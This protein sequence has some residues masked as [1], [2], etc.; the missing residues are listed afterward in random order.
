MRLPSAFLFLLACTGAPATAQMVTQVDTTGQAG[1]P[2]DQAT[3]TH[4]AKI[5]SDAWQRLTVP[6]SVGGRGPFQF[7]VDTGADRTAVSRQVAG[8]L[9]LAPG[10]VAQMH[11]VTGISQVRTTT[12]RGLQISDKVLPTV[13]APLLDAEH[14]GADGILGTDALRAQ[15]VEFDFRKELLSITPSTARPP[16]DEEGTI[17]VQAS[18]REGRLIVTGAEAD[19]TRLTVVLDTG[20]EVTIGNSALRRSLQRRGMLRFTGRVKLLSVTGETIEGDYTVLE[21]LNVGDVEMRNLAVV[22]TDAH[23]FKQMKLESR[24]ALLLGMNALRAFDKVAIDFANRK[25]RLLMPRTSG[26][27]PVMLAAR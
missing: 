11:S 7:L 2:V 12:V 4:E 27:A 14:V 9:G 15:R 25:L 26:R 23:T 13:E 10:P 22:F 18:R 19:R 20:S 16:R 8:R 1:A 21:H 6:V 3:Q 17:V 24:P 5:A